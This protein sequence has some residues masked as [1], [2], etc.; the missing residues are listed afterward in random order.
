[1]SNR[2]EKFVPIIAKQTLHRLLSTTL[3]ASH[4]DNVNILQ[5]VFFVV[6]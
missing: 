6:H 3:I 5:N 4:Q 1:M 2:T